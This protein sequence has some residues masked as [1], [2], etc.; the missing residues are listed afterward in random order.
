MLW[1]PNFGLKYQ[2]PK[3]VKSSR[4]RKR[5]CFC[6]KSSRKR[7]R[8]CFC[9][10]SSRKWKRSCFCSKSSRKSHESVVKSDKKKSWRHDFHSLLF[11]LFLKL[12]DIHIAPVLLLSS[13]F[14]PLFF[15]AV[16]FSRI[17]SS[18][19]F[20]IA[21]SFF[22]FVLFLSSISLRS[23]VTIRCRARKSSRLVPDQKIKRIVLV[24]E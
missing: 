9:S 16:F 13:W 12:L 14:P 11:T 6:S 21:L 22:S 4:K 1:L 8:S 5:L 10:K 3:L 7:K 17:F 2:T 15:S 20:L 18:S 19:L 23:R 24:Q